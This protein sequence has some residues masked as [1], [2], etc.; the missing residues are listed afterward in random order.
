MS[1]LIEQYLSP[2]SFAYI[3]VNFEEDISLDITE[4]DFRY[5]IA[6]PSIPIPVPGSSI[7]QKIDSLL[8]SGCKWELL[9]FDFIRDHAQDMELDGVA[10]VTTTSYLFYPSFDS[11]I[12]SKD[13]RIKTNV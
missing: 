6:M 1:S 10:L 5:L 11:E 4:G 3:L 12:V 8:D 13:V 7:S 2:P 9:D